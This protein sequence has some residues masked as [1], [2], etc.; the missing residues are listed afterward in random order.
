MHAYISSCKNVAL[1][2]FNWL[3]SA[4]KYLGI[5]LNPGLEKLVPQV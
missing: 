4:L 1:L 5:L 3:S 2:S